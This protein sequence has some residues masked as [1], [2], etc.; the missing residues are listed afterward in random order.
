[1]TKLPRRDFLLTASAATL[2]FAAS[3][4]FAAT[5]RQRVLVGSGTPDGILAYD[6]DQASGTLTKAGVAAGFPHTTWIVL[7][8]DGRYLYAAS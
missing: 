6:W 5:G 4:S 7:S 2:A 3:P 8:R 1:M